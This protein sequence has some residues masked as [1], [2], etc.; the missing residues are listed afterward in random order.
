MRKKTVNKK[1]YKERRIA[2]LII[3]IFLIIFLFSLRFFDFN[4]F[5]RGTDT[6]KIYFFD[7]K[8]NE[9]IFEKRT[10]PKYS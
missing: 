2:F 5:N 7:E 9:L 6:A 4:I 3:L 10:I 8:S 1:V